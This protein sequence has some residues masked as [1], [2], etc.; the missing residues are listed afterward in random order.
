MN[1]MIG[2]LQQL[3][4]QGVRLALNAQGQLISQSSKEAV[5]PAIGQ[6]IR[7]HKDALVACLQAR[8]QFTAAIQPQGQDCGPLSSSQ[9]GLWFIE[10]YEESSHLYNMPVY[11]RLIGELD[12]AALEYAFDQLFQRHASLRTRFVRNAEGKGEQQILPH[13]PFR[14]QREDLSAL[15]PAAREQAVAE[16]VRA[17]INRPF[18]LTSGQLTR[19]QLLKLGAREQLLLLTQHHI[20]SDGWSIKNLF[21]DLKPAF[22]AYQNRQPASWQP[23]SLSY[24]DYAR[25]FN[26][27]LFLDYH[28]QFKAFWV[29]RLAGIPEVHGLPLDKPRPAHQDNGGE[30]VFS[31]IDENLWAGFKQLCQR[32]NTSA[33]IGLHALFALLIARLS[34]ERDIV[35]GTPLAYR[36]RPDIEAMLGFFVNT[37]VLRTQLGDSQSFSAYLQAC[38]EQ[39][40]AAFDH[41]LYRFEALSEALGTDR[42]TAINPIFQIMLVYQAKVDFNDLI[43]GCDAVEETSPVLPAKTDI[44]VKVTELM[45]Q[46]RVDWLFATALFERATVQAWADRLL[47]LLQAVVEAPEQDIWQLPLAATP[48]PALPQPHYPDTRTATDLIEHAAQCYPHHPAVRVGEQ[49][50]SYAELDQ[51]AN[52]L[53]HWLLAQGVTPGT[54]IGILA[55]RDIA[56]APALLA[57]WKTGAAYVPLDPAYP[58]QRL[59]HIMTDTQMR[60]VLGGPQP[61]A[62]S[63]PAGVRYLNIRNSALAAELPR[64]APVIERDPQQLA[65]V[66]YTSGSTGLP[67]GVMIEHGALVN[68]LRDHAERLDFGAANGMFNCMSLAFDAGNMA[69]LLPLSTGGALVLGE[70]TADLLEQAEAARSSHMILPVA[71][72]AN[73]A[74]PAETSLSAIGFGGEACPPALVERWGERVALHNMYGPTECTV[75]ALC[76]RLQPGRPVT[77]GQPISGMQALILD[78]LGNLCAPGVPGELCLTGLGLAR[79]YL[80][81]PQRSA[82]AFC[83]RS[84]QGQTVRYYRTGDRARQ[85]ANGD[86]QY[87]GRLDEQVKLRGYRIEPGEIEAQLAQV[88]PAL[89]QV[90]VGV[91]QL[92]ASQQL[93]AYATLR[94]G[95]PAPQTDEVLQ[96]AA[97]RL[98][99]FML[100]SRLILLEQL[101][102]TPNGKLDSQRLPELPQASSAAQA[103][104]PLEEQV[105]GIWQRVLNQPLGVEDDFFRLG[106]DS[107][108][109]IQ[110]STRLRDAGLNCSVKDV[111]EAKTVRRLCRLLQR[112]RAATAI[113]AEQG[114]LQ[115]EFALLPI[116]QWFFE[117]LLARPEHWNQGVL[118]RLPAGTSNQQIQR[119]LSALLLQHDSLRLAVDK[120]GQRYLAEFSLP[121]LPQ[122][123]AAALGES[124]LQQALTELQSRFDPAAGQTLAWARVDDCPPGNSALF[125]AFHHL[126]IDAVSWRILAED[127]ARL[128]AGESL[129]DKTSS[130]RQWGEGLQQYA[131]REQAQFDYWLAQSC[132]GEFGPLSDWRSADGGAAETLLALDAEQTAE[133]VGDANLA[134]GTEVPELLL[135]ALS[136]AL[137]DLGLRERQVIMLEGHGRE[138]I[139]ASLDVSRTVGW[140]TSVYPLAL[141]PQTD[142]AAQLCAVKEQLRAVPN[143]GVGF[144]PL[145]M[146]HPRGAE[147]R[148]AP[149]V[150]NYLGVS[151][152][153][154]GDWTPLPV[155]PGRPLAAANQPEE[156][157]SLHGGV[158]GGRLMLRQVGSLRQDL[159]E[160]LMRDLQ[161]HVQ[162]V[163]LL[164]REQRARGRRYT[165]S[166][167]P[168]VRLSQQQLDRL[169]GRYQVEHLLPLS[170]LQESMLHQAALCPQDSAYHLQTPIRYRQ[171]LDIA[172]YRRAWQ[173]RLDCLP[174]LRA[175]LISGA[176]EPLQLI[177]REVTVP[178]QFE[179][180]SAET[181]AQQ[182]IAEYCAADLAN[183][184][185]LDCPPLLRLACFK[186]SAQDYQVIFSCHHALLDGWSGPQLLGAVHRDYLAVVQGEPLDASRDDCYLAYGAYIASQRAEASAYWQQQVELLSHDTALDALFGC[187][188]NANPTQQQPAVCAQAL[189][190]EAQALLS[191]RATALGVTPGLLAQYAWHRLLARRCGFACTLVGNVAAGREYPLEGIDQSVGLYINSLPLALD[192]RQP[193]TL[194]QHILQLQTRLMELNQHATQSLIALHQGRKRLFQSL[195]VY[196]NYP[197]GEPPQWSDAR[198]LQPEFGR[199]TEKVELPLNLVVRE[200]DGCLLLRFEFDA[201]LIAPARA[202]QVLAQWQAELR[203]LVSESL[204]QPIVVAAG[205]QAA[206]AKPQKLTPPLPLEDDL[207]AQLA[208]CWQQTLCLSEPVWQQDFACLGVDSLQQLRLLRALQPLLPGQLSLAELKACGS[209]AALY[210]WL[211]AEAP[212]RREAVR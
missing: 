141:H 41:Q 21:A 27:S 81:L 83:Q 155:A 148:M 195:F 138:A 103:D 100:P 69:A 37:L 115:G 124:G 58:A 55:Q 28:Q 167:F 168:L 87:L 181:D 129:P 42:T 158:F 194:Q 49:S 95:E 193:L 186:L 75:T 133:L 89:Q 36:E 117:Q 97:A 113:R 150:F 140:F 10:Q 179:D 43:P 14:L 189:D 112:Q 197:A 6:Q 108:L 131:A 172:A 45:D 94:P 184:F 85:L 2:L 70:P 107:I 105:L 173:Q 77:I 154:E 130:Y 16:R 74:P 134:F 51:R 137:A 34:G 22:L 7:E 19:V 50:M 200:Q 139:E 88:A 203:A 78:E 91:A 122:L 11:F 146:H 201:A 151:M 164:C 30:L 205:A 125:L 71:L 56:F 12:E 44:S 65:Q 153:G 61:Q 127:L 24:I 102:L 204:Q 170:S 47:H 126:V 15:P 33:F 119:W 13:Q 53:A 60:W 98:P 101:P 177:S 26:S 57:I 191:A 31:A 166:D 135:T 1:D 199:A 206:A 104:T 175:A 90:R 149:V 46:V 159:S 63:L 18:D 66:I 52:Q 147:L 128:A 8:Q 92:G 29:E 145:R 40:L 86:Y 152:A 171:P 120:Q 3:E 208:D 188:L 62:L 96:L 82:E 187:D 73:L 174:A 143:K 114:A 132:G 25:W 17:E 106:G 169:L 110:L 20:I 116:Q 176:G 118:L 123:N 9:S 212:L 185:A 165:P 157:I 163:L 35:I 142:L 196:E 190:S 68:L 161:R 198:A 76:A 210:R 160:Q 48:L 64:S 111:F 162:Q 59:A 178:L 32:H 84:L 38:R 79:G 156:L 144:N 4:R 183:P 67:K 209:P 121:P 211:R 93:V 182:R 5:T 72:L 180:L 192:W 99:E 54:P 80:N 39:D 23:M 136:G 202:E 109:S 207:A